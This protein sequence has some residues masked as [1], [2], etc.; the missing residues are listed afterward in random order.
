MST[1]M[2]HDWVA[3]HASRR[4]DAPALTT[5]ERGAT[6]SWGEL[7]RRVSRL[8][9]VLLV[10]HGL[11]AGD[12]IAMIAENDS[13]VFELQFACM[14]SGLILVPLNWRLAIGELVGLVRDARPA[15][16]VHDAAWAE[17]AQHIAKK[18]GIHGLLAW[19]DDQAESAYDRAV[20]EASGGI[21]GGRHPESAHTHILYTSGTTGLPKGA[22]CSQGTLRHHAL[23]M[24][25]TCRV[26]ERG[27][28]H[29]NIVPL[30]HAGALNTY[31][32]PI[33]HWGGHVTTIR[34]FD[35]AQVLAMLADPALSITHMCGVLQMY[36]A[37][38]DLP[39]FDDTEFP[40]LRSILFGGWGPG[41]VPVH[42]RWHARGVFPQL[43]YGS[44]EQGPLVS[45]LEGDPALAAENCSG[46][47]VAGVELRIVDGDGADLPAGAIGEIVSRGPSITPGY[48]NR[49]RQDHFFGDWFRTGDAGR[50]DEHGRLYVVDRLKEV[51][52]SGGENI[53]PAEI[54]LALSG[55]P[56]VAEIC[57][58]GVP[59][60][61][62]GEV[63]LAVVQPLPGTTVTLDILLDHA[64][65]RIARFK[66]PKRLALVDEMPRNV[67]LKIDRALLKSRHG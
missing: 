23:N 25:Q 48:W 50:L 16:L 44:T 12:R 28:H 55:A 36:E 4:P 2:V 34:R 31:S 9:H 15:L 8:S 27:S 26:A 58:I 30:F 29:L 43:A 59:D 51:Y 57:V 13:R 10:E 54:E 3:Y 52:R 47:A 40:A 65:G 22:L 32:N 5:I 53:Y 17:T 14:R 41:S 62:W 39:G 33:L 24:A 64:D 56:G 49:P 67:T 20:E 38:A 7:H 35:P 37:I 6:M 63:G 19:A 11:A 18:A 46:P 60:D 42:Q 1:A 66:W 61:R 21:A 45:V